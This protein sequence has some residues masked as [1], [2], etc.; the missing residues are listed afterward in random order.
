MPL[1]HGWGRYRILAMTE[2]ECFIVSKKYTCLIF[3]NNR[4]QNEL[5]IFIWRGHT[6]RRGFISSYIREI[7]SSGVT[8]HA[9]IFIYI[10]VQDLH[11]V[12]HVQDDETKKPCRRKL[13]F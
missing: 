4:A 2:N 6:Y 12:K 11:G 10:T 8:A 1:D 5:C 7:L 3:K 9:S 13:F